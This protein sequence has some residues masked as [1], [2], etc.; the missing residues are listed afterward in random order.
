MAAAVSEKPHKARD[1]LAKSNLQPEP[2]SQYVRAEGVMIVLIS[3]PLNK[4]LVS[5]MK[6]AVVHKVAVLEG[7]TRTTA[8]SNLSNAKF[9]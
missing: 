8:C 2:L 5:A 4:C 7:L 9:L 6:N 1:K 3:K